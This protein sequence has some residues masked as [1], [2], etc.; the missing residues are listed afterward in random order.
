MRGKIMDIKRTNGPD[1]FLWADENGNIWRAYFFDEASEIRIYRQDD[2]GTFE[3]I[4]VM[5]RLS[6]AKY[7]KIKKQI[8][9][10]IMYFRT[11]IL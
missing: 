9:S 1:I 10:K 5:S 6:T 8:K 3:I 2:Y 7:S 4:A 11:Q